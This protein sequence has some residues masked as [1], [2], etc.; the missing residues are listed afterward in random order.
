MPLPGAGRRPRP[1][2]LASLVLVDILVF[3]GLDEMDAWGPAEVFC[4]AGKRGPDI[5]TRLMTRLAQDTV[6]GV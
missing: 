5:R 3:C 1:L 6:L 2:A 4:S